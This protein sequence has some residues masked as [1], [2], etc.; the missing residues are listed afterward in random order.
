MQEFRIFRALGLAFKAWFRNFIP[1]TL[2]LAVLYGPLVYWVATI[3]FGSEHLDEEFT[4]VFTRGVLFAVAVSTLLPPL[5][6]Y[7]VVQDLNGTKVSMLTSIKYGMRGVLAAVVLGVIGV[8]AGFVP[9]GGIAMLVLNCVWFVTTPAAVAERLN[10]FAAMG[11]S[12]MLTQGRR[13]GIFGL[14]LLMGIALIAFFFLMILPLISD[15]SNGEEAVASL[16]RFSIIMVIVYAISQMFSGI[17][18]AVS[19]ALLRQDKEGVSHDELA[20]V[21]E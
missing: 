2:L 5:L 1:F 3:N 17:V 10:P 13:W 4:S 16:R 11:R 7:R 12:S 18:A 8:V 6:T 15:N 21:F 20:K 9:F 19:Y 14:I